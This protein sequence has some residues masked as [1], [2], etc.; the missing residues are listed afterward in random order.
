ME[1]KH[2]LFLIIAVAVF[3]L[4]VVGFIGAKQT[5]KP[6]F[7]IT[8]HSMQPAY[9]NWEASAHGDIDCMTCHS[10]PGFSGFVK[11]KLDGVKQVAVTLTSD[12]QP[13]DVIGLAHVNESVCLSCHEQEAT[14]Q[15]VVHMIHASQD[16]SCLDCHDRVI[17]DPPEQARPDK[18]Q[19]S[20]QTCHRQ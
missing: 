4:L 13:E 14:D 1:S 6:E 20:C 18:T 7:C 16:Y 2:K 17:H 8:C 11:T 5:S 9:E 15:V 19:E 3:G 12:V 10:E